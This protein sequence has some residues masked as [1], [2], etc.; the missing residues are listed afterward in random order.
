VIE[1]LALIA[2]LP[3]HHGKPPHRQKSQQT[4]SLFAEYHEPFFNGI[5]QMQTFPGAP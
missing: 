3:A 1:T 5:G 4:E 2:P